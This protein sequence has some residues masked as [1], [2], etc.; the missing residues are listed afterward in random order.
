MYTSLLLTGPST[1]AVINAALSRPSSI[2]SSFI[3]KQ[4]RTISFS[5][6]ISDP[7]TVC[8]GDDQE[9]CSCDN[10]SYICEDYDT[11]Q[12]CVTCDEPIT[13]RTMNMAVKTREGLFICGDCDLIN[14]QMAEDLIEEQSWCQ[15][16]GYL[17][18]CDT[19][20][21]FIGRCDNTRL[22]F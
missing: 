14:E 4:P 16:C 10:C 6:F 8:F 2:T 9:F 19:K 21:R 20:G 18:P 22:P 12:A 17:E 1:M 3:S 15:D 11:L 7:N 5:S 13:D